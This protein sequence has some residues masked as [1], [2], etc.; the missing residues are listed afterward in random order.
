MSEHEKHVTEV[1]GL[2]DNFD[3]LQ[4]AV[5]ELQITGV[6][7][8]QISIAGHSDVLEA[9]YPDAGQSPASPKQD[10]HD[11]HET[12]VGDVVGGFIGGLIAAGGL[13]IPSAAVTTIA[14]GGIGGA[15][16]TE[17]LSD[18]A[19]E[20][21]HD[22]IR[23]RIGEGEL[24]LCVAVSDEDQEIKA[25]SILEKHHAKDIQTI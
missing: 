9:H 3:Y 15:V 14:L 22:R 20:S 10:S 21:N 1:V 19:E 18:D 23:N 17:A 13:L 8:E 2:F 5:D 12:S 25:K 4:T 16:V 24:A 7:S 6:N 11:D